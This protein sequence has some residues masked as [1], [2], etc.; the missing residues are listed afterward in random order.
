[1]NRLDVEE[2]LK[3]KV[4]EYLA[5]GELLKEWVDL[6]KS[7]KI[8]V[9]DYSLKKLTKLKLDDYVIGHGPENKSFCYRIECE[10]DGLGR[11]RGAR[12]DK[13]GVYFGKITQRRKKPD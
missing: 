10:L 5:D 4:P 11:I 13:F 1:M 6:E 3:E 8:F 7:R 9:K 2:L 12:A